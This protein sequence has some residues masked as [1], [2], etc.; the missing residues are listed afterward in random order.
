MMI[1]KMALLIL[2]DRLRDMIHASVSFNDLDVLD[3]QVLS[4]KD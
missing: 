3:W 1:P 4:R 2:F